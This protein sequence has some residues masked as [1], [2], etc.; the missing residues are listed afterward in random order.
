MPNEPA[1]QPHANPMQRIEERSL[2]LHQ[3]AVRT[4][5]EDPRALERARQT[6]RRW[7]SKYGSEAPKALLEWEEIL[8]KPVEQIIEVS[9]QRTQYGARIRKSSPLSIL[10]SRQE[11]K[12]AYESR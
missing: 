8:A 11:R 1:V 12:K 5:R 9:L 2:R 3:A 7:I 4:L 10:V 6:L